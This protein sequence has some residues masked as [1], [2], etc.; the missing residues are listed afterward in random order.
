MKGTNV[1]ARLFALLMVAGIM[2]CGDDASGP[3]EPGLTLEESEAL[4]EALQRLGVQGSGEELT[5]FGGTTMIACP[6]GGEITA[7]GTAIPSGTE[8]SPVV[9]LDVTLV[10]ADCVVT[11]SGRTFSLN[12]APSIR[13]TGTF[14]LSMPEELVFRAEVDFSLFG[15]LR[16]HLESRSGN[17]DVSVRQILQV[18]LAALTQTGRATGTLCGHNI[19]ADLSGPVPVI[20]D[21]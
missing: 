5:P 16:Y 15:T 14:G 21:P 6:G 2:A 9:T 18:D 12:G 8:T 7:T 17:C 4:V 1:A 13:Q 11:A 19:D 10:P 20:P 3:E